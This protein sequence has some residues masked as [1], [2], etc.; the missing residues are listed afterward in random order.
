MPRSGDRVNRSVRDY[1]SEH[2]LRK[3]LAAMESDGVAAPPLPQAA[4]KKMAGLDWV[5]P[6]LDP[7]TTE[8]QSMKE[9]LQRLLV[10]KSY[11]ILDSEREASFER[12][13]GLAC[14]IFKVPIALVSVVDLGR[15]W[16]MSNRGLGDVRETPRR[17]AFCAH[18]IQSKEGDM[19]VVPDA[20]QDVRFQENPL[21]KG[22]PNIR[23]YAG[24]V[25]RSSFVFRVSLI[26][27]LFLSHVGCVSMSSS[28]SVCSPCVLLF[29]H[30]P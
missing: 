22:P 27:S 2:A 14:R 29:S 6:S 5:L 9:E 19:L 12:L 18:A 1:D 3:A 16:F 8:V 4:D 10:L 23:F 15:Q 11:L 20:T 26:S 28:A 21:V 30:S 13:T 24:A 7:D 17:H 25:R